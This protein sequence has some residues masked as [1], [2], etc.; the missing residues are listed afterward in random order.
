MFNIAWQAL[1]VFG[2]R[3]TTL[4]VIE[5][6]FEIAKFQSSK[7]NITSID[8]DMPL[9]IDA[10]DS[11][12]CTLYQCLTRHL[13]IL[14]DIDQEVSQPDRERAETLVLRELNTI[15]RKAPHPSLTS[16]NEPQFSDLIEKEIERVTTNRVRKGGVDTTRYDIPDEPSSNA[17]TDEWRKTL[18]VAYISSAYLSE[19]HINL[20]LLEEHGK[21]AWLVGN[22][23]L[24]YILKSLDQDYAR[25]KEETDSINRD[26]K[27][28]QEASKAELLG[29]ED[30]WKRGIGKLIE[31]QL[32]T[33][34]LQT[35]A[36][37]P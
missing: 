37:G 1:S 18:R 14:I 13:L 10:H 27:L 6:F 36:S 2:L 15:D 17:K 8:L 29:L 32:A 12:P 28:T 22:S 35:G 21:N 34:E 9:M 26:R 11:L 23:Q 20:S 25:L 5:F 4:R 30:T 7:S 19:R 33:Q 31:V 24:E 3:F 16:F